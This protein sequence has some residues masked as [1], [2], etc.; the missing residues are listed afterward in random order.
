MSEILKGKKALLLAEGCR[1]RKEQKILDERLGKIKAELGL[2]AKGTYTNGSGDELVIAETE[3]YSEI[4]PKTVLDYLKRKNM[5]SRFPE[6]VKVQIVP[7]RKV[8]PDSMI[9]K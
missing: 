6:I 9:D 3:K 8:V 4:S 2:T 7:L 5:A 1:I